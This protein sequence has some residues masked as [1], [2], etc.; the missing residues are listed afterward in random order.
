MHSLTKTWCLALGHALLMPLG[1]DGQMFV[2]GDAQ[3][4]LVTN[5]VGGFLGQGVSFMDFNG[6]DL[7]DLTFTQFEG[8]LFAYVNN[9]QGGFTPQ[10]LGIGEVLEQP[11]SALWVNFG[12]RWGQGFVGHAAPG[13]Q[14][15]VRTHARW[16]LA[17]GAQR[18]RTGLGFWR[19]HLW[20]RCCRLRPR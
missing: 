1:V 14:C 4:T 12:Q 19:T 6:D 20:G 16:Q 2:E 11:K 13:A 8:E 18:W 10:D 7:D 5:H 9:G 15:I 3:G 17:G